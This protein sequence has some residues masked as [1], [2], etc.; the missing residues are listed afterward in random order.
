MSLQ[1]VILESA[2]HDLKELREYIVKNFSV[3]SWQDTYAKLKQAIRNLQTFP[4]AGFLPEEIEKLNLSQYRQI[5]S[6]MNRII[7]E[8]RQEI[9]YI[10]II[11]DARRDMPSLLTR[12]LLRTT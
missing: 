11:V 9:I 3:E 6:G 8:V 2:E 1:V 10:H 4:Q 7:Y 5:L 12:R